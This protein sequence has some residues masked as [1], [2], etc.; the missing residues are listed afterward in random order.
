M[1]QDGEA[2][3]APGSQPGRGSV[4]DP[5]QE[6]GEGLGQEVHFEEDLRGKMSLPGS[7]GRGLSHSTRQ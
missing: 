1:G 4:E 3:P 5:E 7:A 6:G 2:G